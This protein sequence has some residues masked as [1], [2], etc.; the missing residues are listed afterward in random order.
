MERI[1]IIGCGGTGAALVAVNTELAKSRGSEQA[2]LEQEG[3]EHGEK[4]CKRALVCNRVCE[5]FV[6]PARHILDLRKRWGDD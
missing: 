3:S 6:Y 4:L 2:L 5:T 1:I